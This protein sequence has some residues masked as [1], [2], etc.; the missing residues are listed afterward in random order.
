[1][2]S[3]IIFTIL[4]L[5]ASNT[6]MTLAWYLHVKKQAWPLVTAILISWMIAL[7]EY[8]LQ[9]P[10]NRLGHQDFGGPFSLPQLKV[11]QESITLIV[12]SVLTVLVFKEKLRT[13][14]LIAFAL[15]FVAVAVSVYGRAPHMAQSAPVINEQGPA[16]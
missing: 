16:R 8:I 11:L 3:R 5:V 13:T 14:D 6:F 9:V 2:T 10:A 1:M 12:F 4:L 15:V 7:P